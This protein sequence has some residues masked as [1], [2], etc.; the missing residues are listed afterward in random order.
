MLALC[1]IGC[2]VAHQGAFEIQVLYLLISL[3]GQPQE[4][5]RD[6]KARC[7]S[8]HTRKSDSKLELPQ[9]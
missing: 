9:T 7:V 8:S 3:V 1:H 6:A 2:V 4:K 5:K